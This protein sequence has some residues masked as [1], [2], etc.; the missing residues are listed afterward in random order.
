M[1]QAPLLPLFDGLADTHRVV[2]LAQM[3]ETLER[4]D[5]AIALAVMK[6]LM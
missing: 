6:E 2:Q 5:G 1:G 4:V 3:P